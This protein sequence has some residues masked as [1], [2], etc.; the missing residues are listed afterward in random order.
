MV[1]EVRGVMVPILTPLTE[2]EIVD[3]ASLRRLVDY[4]IDGG[5]HGIWAAGT[6]GEFAALDDSQRQCRYFTCPSGA[7]LGCVNFARARARQDAGV[8][9]WPLLGKS[10]G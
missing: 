7:A 10:P 5:V 4:L 3:E 1:D 8:S 2:D 6:T 9:P